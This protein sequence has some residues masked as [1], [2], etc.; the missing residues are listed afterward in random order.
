MLPGSHLPLL[1]IGMELLRVNGYNLALYHLKQSMVI[2]PMDPLNLNELGVIEFKN[3]RF[4][5]AIEL[6]RRVIKSKDDQLTDIIETAFFNLAHCFRKKRNFSKAIK[7]YKKALG[8]VP[9]NASSYSA[10]GY[11]YHLMGDLGQAIEY[12]HQS[13]GFRADDSLTSELLGQAIRSFDPFKQI[14]LR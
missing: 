6:F 8:I 11:T 13:L 14:L 1:S 7:Y 2:C 10:L 3:N 9:R 12:Y 5:S 4:D